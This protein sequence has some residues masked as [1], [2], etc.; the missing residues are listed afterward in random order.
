MSII[1][2]FTFPHFYFMLST[3]LLISI[4]IY[5]VLAH[6]PENW[7]FLHKLFMGLGLIVA[8]VGLIVVGALRLT[9]IH[10]IL[11][12]ITVILLTLSIIGGLYATK[13]Q[14]KKL[15]TGH[16]WFGRLVYLVALIVIIIGILTLLGII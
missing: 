11:G 14:E 16:I 15:R 10:A 13:K 7:F 5:F 12:L 4:G 3:L 1:D 8:I 6:N 2:L 9:I